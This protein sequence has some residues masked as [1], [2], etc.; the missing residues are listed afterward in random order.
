M[1]NLIVFPSC[2]LFNRIIIP[3]NHQKNEIHIL[4]ISMPL[5]D[6]A[7]HNSPQIHFLYFRL[8]ILSIQFDLPSNFLLLRQS[9]SN[10]SHL[11]RLFFQSPFSVRLVVYREPKFFSH[12]DLFS[13][14]NHSSPSNE[15]L[16]NS[17]TEE[18]PTPHFHF[19]RKNRLFNQLLQR[20]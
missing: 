1:F 2:I 4:V 10:P 6:F 11:L 19:F 16:R 5:T 8:S 12:A 15:A 7:F 3:I 9:H 14:K 20:F 17:R 18:Q 13:N